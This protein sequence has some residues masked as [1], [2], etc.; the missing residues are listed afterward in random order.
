MEGD[1]PDTS[2]VEFPDEALVV[3][4]R[5]ERVQQRLQQM[6]FSNIHSRLCEATLHAKNPS[7]SDLALLGKLHIIT[8]LGARGDLHLL[9][10]DEE[11]N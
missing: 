6:Q 4:R 1:I 7:P 9:L 10:G 5:N 11:K 2:G 8:L 3:T